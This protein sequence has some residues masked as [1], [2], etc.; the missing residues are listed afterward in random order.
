MPCCC[1]VWSLWFASTASL[2]AAPREEKAQYRSW[3]RVVDVYD[4]DTITLAM[5]ERGHVV[6]RRCRCVGYDA[7]EMRGPHKEEAIAAR[8]ALKRVLPRRAFRVSITGLDKYG[9]LLVDLRHDG[10]AVSD[11]MVSLGHGYYY[12]GGKKCLPSAS[13]SSKTR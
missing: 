2:S 4:G 3:A 8:E 1:P 11:I 6:R 5:I 13:S 7:P 12:D 10:R 9:R